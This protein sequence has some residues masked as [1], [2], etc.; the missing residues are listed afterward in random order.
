MNSSVVSPIL[1]VMLAIFCLMFFF[2]LYIIKIN[3]NVKFSRDK[4]IAVEADHPNG[5]KDRHFSREKV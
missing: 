5:E 4:E 2:H 3:V 1:N